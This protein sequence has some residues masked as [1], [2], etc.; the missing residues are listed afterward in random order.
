MENEAVETLK[1]IWLEMKGLN[2]R[3]DRTNERLEGLESKVDTT[4]QRLEGLESRVDTTN[5]RLERL[6]VRLDRLEGET[7]EVRRAVV[8]S[9]MRLAT[10]VVALVGIMK[11]VRDGLLAAGQTR[12]NLFEERLVRLEQRLA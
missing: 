10:E 12:M 9:H 4:N 11:D 6:D 1:L 7:E 5:Q 3:V 8:E 2:G